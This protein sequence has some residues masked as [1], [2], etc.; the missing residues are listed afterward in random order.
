MSVGHHRGPTLRTGPHRNEMSFSFKFWEG[1]IYK[2][3]PSGWPF[4]LQ[5][6]LTATRTRKQ[7]IDLT[8]YK[9]SL[10]YSCLKLLEMF[11]LPIL[12]FLLTL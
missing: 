8:P 3:M 7:M 10:D 9:L 5:N 6:L 12:H 2:Y 4:A 1:L 11:K